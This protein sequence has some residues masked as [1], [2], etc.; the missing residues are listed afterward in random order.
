MRH[1]RSTPRRVVTACLATSA[2]MAG[3]GYG[4]G[5]AAEGAIR[6]ADAPG[7][8]KDAYIVVFKDSAVGA[9]QAPAKAGDLAAKY[10]GKVKLTYTAALRGFSVSMSEAQARKLAADPAVDYVEQDGIAK[11]TGVQDNPTWGLDRVDQKNLPLDK[12]YNYA[13]TASNVTA[14]VVDTGV[15]KA[16]SDFGGRAVDGYDFID[17]D[18]VAQDCNGH[19]THVAGTIGSTTYGVAKGVKLVGVRVLNCQG[20]G[21]WS[22]VIGGIDWVAKNAVKPAVANLSLGGGADSSVD[23]A[24]KRAVA[25]GVT[26]AVAAGNDNKDACSTSPART[27]EA[28]TVNATDSSDT[29]STFSNYGSCTDIFAPGTGITSTWNNGS[30]NSIS[31]TSMATPHVAGAAALYLSGNTSATPAQVSKALTDNA[32]S[33]VVKNAGSGSPNK[34]LYTGFIGDS[35]PCSGGSNADDVAIPDAGSAVSSS[36][37]VTGCEGVGSASTSVKVDINHSYTGDLAIDLVGPSGNA[38]VLRKAGGVGSASG[39]H[40]TFTVNTGPENKNGTW[41]LRVTDVYSYDTGNVDGWSL[42]F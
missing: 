8:V 6:G 5:Y 41:K 42:S 12:K 25:A 4:Y 23:N 2:L 18:S 40:E 29:R 3:V 31:G 9:P 15:H 1:D 14:Y 13:N 28:I 37:T 32:T 35:G 36:V 22:Q 19:G 11:A 33:G 27:P 17:N 20:Q 38:I 24:V 21:E 7:A 30:T 39:I 16:H 26:F 10:G 34:L